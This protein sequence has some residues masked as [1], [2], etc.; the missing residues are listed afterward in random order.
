MV[1]SCR[2]LLTIALTV[3]LS[4]CGSFKQLSSPHT[5]APNQQRLKYQAD[6]SQY[7]TGSIWPDLVS[8][9]QIYHY[10]NQ[11]QV[12]HYIHYYQTHHDKVTI[13]LQRS[14]PFLFDILQSLKRRQLP[15][16]LALLPVIESGYRGDAVSHAGAVG[17]WQ[18][19]PAT[20]KRFHVPPSS[21]W[22]NGRRNI[23]AATDA[24][25]QYF[26]ILGRMFND[27]WPL[28]I[29][30][31]N[32]GEGTIQSAIDFNARHKLPVD[33]WH[34]DL[35]TET[36]NYVP[37]LLALAI[38]VTHPRHYGFT[39]PNIPDRPQIGRVLI[40]QQIDLSLAAGFAEI[41]LKQLYTLNPQFIRRAT[42][43]QGHYYLT[44]PIQ[45]I[46]TFQHNLHHFPQQ[47]LVNWQRYTVKK[48][49]TLSKVAMQTGT[50]VKDLQLANHLV[51]TVIYPGQS[52][53]YP[54]NANNRHFQHYTVKPGDTLSHIAREHEVSLT[55]LMRWNQLNEQS[56]LHPGQVLIIH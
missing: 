52:L 55:S 42:P 22:Y 30:A 50:S 51:G 2:W 56:V 27:N 31:Y 44:L 14:T 20:A 29:A 43:P 40:T 12:Q 39:L 11:P 17:L 35:P 23:S 53:I 33:F 3:L 45:H 15:G 34:L 26:Q 19:M 48:G 10:P 21:Y 16:E 28:A 4:G 7:P 6:N 54:I 36:E 41:S 49:D 38:L 5:Q 46:R 8:S 24:A 32:A 18:L 1:K 25:L 47:S 37:K 13:A 9:F